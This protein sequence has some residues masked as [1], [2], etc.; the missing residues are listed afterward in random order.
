MNE[1][2][3]ADRFTHD[4]DDLL[5]AAG[6]SEAAP[7]P[8]GYRRVL[9]VAQALAAADLSRDSQARGSLRRRL[10]ARV[11]ARP[12]D[13]A[14]RRSAS[15]LH[16][17]WRR[18]PALAVATGLLAL[19]LVVALAWPGALAA[20]AQGIAGLVRDLRLGE[21][22]WIRQ[23][24]PEG[25]VPAP[26]PLSAPEVELRG[27]H[28]II[29]TTIGNFAGDLRPGEDVLR[30]ASFDQVQ[31]AAPFG[32]RWPTDLPA[33][34]ALRE[35]MVAPMDWVFLFFDGPE[36][37]IILVQIPVFEK[38]VERSAGEVDVDVVG[39]GMLTDDPIEEVELAGRPA[40]W[41]DGYGLMWE[42]D[43]TSYT[44]GGVN[45]SLEATRRIA[46]SLR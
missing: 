31:A 20:A 4:V 2:D 29:R 32:L 7:V 27:D 28:W 34:Y 10:L 17:F 14:R 19:V 42:A 33:G 37:E 22:T 18:R 35:G 43:G 21:F 41:I 8:A 30:F 36:G 15:P 12:G 40:G 46:E 5:A 6:R 11:D 13:E 23:V 16:T 24:G 1:Q 38:V 45:L 3:W 25:S 9:D 39:V 26:A 44:L